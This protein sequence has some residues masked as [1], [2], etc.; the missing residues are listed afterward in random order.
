[1][2][3]LLG[4]PPL[5]RCAPT[6]RSLATAR[7][8]A[9]PCSTSHRGWPRR[10]PPSRRRRRFRPH[11]LSSRPARAPRCLRRRSYYSRS[12][13]RARAQPRG[14]GSASWELFADGVKC[15]REC[16]NEG[17]DA[18][19]RRVWHD[20]CSRAHS[21]AT[22]ERP[23][24]E[25]LAEG[26]ATGI[27]AGLLFAAVEILVAVARGF[28]ALLPGA[29][30]GERGD[31]R[32]RPVGT[33]RRRG[34]GGR[35]AGSSGPQRGIRR[36]LCSADAAHRDRAPGTWS[37]RRSSHVVRWS[38]RSYGSS[39]SR[40][41]RGYSIRGSCAGPWQLFLHVVFFG[42]PLAFLTTFSRRRVKYPQEEP[43]FAHHGAPPS[44]S[45]VV[46]GSSTQPGSEGGTG[47]WECGAGRR[48]GTL[49]P[50]GWLRNS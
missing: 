42:L 27:A 41:S 3:P 17:R 21:M 36:A 34:S 39:T 35:C 48:A 44:L 38:R 50:F 46:N 12:A 26:V 10:P 6:G 32:V 40:S 33:R 11:P 9:G 31:G 43:E 7:R 8:T 4:A 14:R 1:M 16:G 19:I 28:P 23:S 47:V 25:A 29:V 30:R 13:H 18:G 15:L 2:P 20:H 24:N 22:H 5:C 49:A 45:G 37:E